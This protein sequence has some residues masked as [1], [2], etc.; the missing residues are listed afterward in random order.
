MEIVLEGQSSLNE[1]KNNDTVSFSLMM[2]SLLRFFDAPS[3][4]YMR[5]CPSVCPSV[6]GSISIKEKRVPGAS[7]VGYPT[8][9]KAL[10]QFW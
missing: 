1:V 6:R 3:H 9:F 2:E 4:L 8:L 10:A 5:V 7:Y